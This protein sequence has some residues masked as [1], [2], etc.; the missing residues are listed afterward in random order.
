MNATL[1]V[2]TILDELAQ[3]AIRIVN[4]ESG[5]AG[6]R[7][8]AGMT[9]HK[10]FRQG[11]AIPFEYTWPPGQG[12]PGWVLEHKVPYGTSDAATDPVM[13]HRS[14]HQYRCP[15]DYLYADPEFVW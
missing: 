2:D 11:V 9:V 5:F 3:E 13:Q 8:A 15:L 14:R 10:Y 7:T 12:I 1:D 4:G 6:L